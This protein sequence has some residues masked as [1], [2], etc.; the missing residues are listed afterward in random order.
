MFNVVENVSK[1]IKWLDKNSTEDFVHVSSANKEPYNE[2]TGYFIPTL[3]DYGMK[4]KA[5]SFC[6]YLVREQ[7]PN[8]SWF[9]HRKCQQEYFF[10]FDVAQIVDGLSSFG[11]L[12]GSSIEKANKW[13]MSK[14]S[15]GKF[16]DPYDGSISEHIYPRILYCLQKAGAPISSLSYY[17]KDYEF[18]CLSHFYAYAFEGATRLGWDNSKFIDVLR[19]YD[20]KLPEKMGMSSYCYTGISQS[21]VALFLSGEYDLG[22]KALEFVSSKQNPSGGFFGSNGQYFPNEEISWAVKFYLDAVQEAQKCWFK[23][24][25]H[26]FPDYFENGENDNRLNFIRNN[27]AETDKVLEVGSGMGRYINNLKCDRYACDIIDTSKHLD[28]KASVGSALN[29]PYEDNKFDVVFCC[30]SL[31]HSLLPDMAIQE[32]LRVLRPGGKLLIVDKDKKNVFS[33]ILFCEQWLD[34]GE[35]KKKYNATVSELSQEKLFCPFFG[36]TIMK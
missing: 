5:K 21:A 14:A 6:S 9:A 7:M 27:I 20:G 2:V 30:E 33:G 8:G 1:A 26:I 17:Q 16:C 28:A 10:P 24:H 25:F 3:I 18:S 15:N 34:F 29:L 12:F 4:K 13:I 36:A 19:K 23:K 22:M 31:E 35:I 11:S 32:C